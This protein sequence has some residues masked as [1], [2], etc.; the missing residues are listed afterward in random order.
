MTV[1]EFLFLPVNLYPFCPRQV[2]RVISMLPEER[3]GSEVLDTIACA[4]IQ[5]VSIIV[6]CDGRRYKDLLSY[7]RI[8]S[9]SKYYCRMRW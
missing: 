4:Y 1:S 8:H 7:L 6:V 9:D 2:I 3:R 5:T